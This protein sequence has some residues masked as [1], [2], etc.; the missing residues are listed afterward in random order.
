MAELSNASV[1][2]CTAAIMNKARELG[3]S[4]VGICSVEELRSS[5][6]FAMAPK[7]LNAEAGRRESDVG[8]KPGEV[9]WPE[10]AKS[11][12]VI[13]Y[14]HPAT[15]PEL[16]WWHG[17]SD[18]PGNRVLASIIRDLSLWVESEY[19]MKSYPLPYH[20]G[21]GGIF[22]KDAAVQSGLGCIGRNNLLI[23]PEYG[24]RVRLRAMLLT[25]RLP[26]TG[27]RRFDP[28]GHCAGPC[29]AVCPQ[30]AFSEA[31]HPASAAGQPAPPGNYDRHKCNIQMNEDISVA[32]EQD[33]PEVS[34]KPV[35]I[36]KYCRHCELSC[37]V[38]R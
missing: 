9:C 6:S 8:L 11:A 14:A 31:V 34:D 3:A 12:V 1:L 25:E 5:P 33:V 16:D 24:P 22:L 30:K 18:P 10:D 19:A 27:P 15:E 7:V 28:C 35:R 17:R 4:L 36:V 38:G 37:P 29:L 23:T 32:K 26:A 2:Q 21:K 20:V 13:A